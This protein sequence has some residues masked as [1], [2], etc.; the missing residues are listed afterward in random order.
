M[1]IVGDRWTL[2]IL[3][4]LANGKRRYK[5]F[6]DSPERIASNILIARLAAMERDGLIGAKPYQLRPKR[7]E[8]RLTKKGAALLPVL[9]AICRWGEANLAKRW[10]APAAF[11]DKRPEDLA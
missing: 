9:Q 10:K 2:V 1:E 4:D 3:R 11:M 6:L 5:D 8:Y 7:F